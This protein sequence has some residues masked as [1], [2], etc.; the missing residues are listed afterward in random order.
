LSG[1][2]RLKIEAIIREQKQN[3]ERATGRS[4]N[5]LREE[6]SQ[7]EGLMKPLEGKRDW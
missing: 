2:F 5:F 6:G 3:R 1:T 4:S 7:T